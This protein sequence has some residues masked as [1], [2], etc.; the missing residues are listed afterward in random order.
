MDNTIMRILVLILCTVVLWLIQSNITQ[1]KATIA[2]KIQQ[3]E[4]FIVGSK[5]GAEKKAWVIAQLRI[6]GIRANV[7]INWLIDWLVKRI[8]K[9]G[10]WLANATHNIFGGGCDVESEKTTPDE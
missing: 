7:F 10:G 6:V 2:E 3:A 8:N 5:L 9:E 4:A 1:L